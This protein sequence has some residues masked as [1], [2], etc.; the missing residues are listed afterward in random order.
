MQHAPDQSVKLDHRCLE[1]KRKVSQKAQTERYL[2][3]F[4]VASLCDL[5]STDGSGGCIHGGRCTTNCQL[6][7][8]VDLHGSSSER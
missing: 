2:E 4:S 1:L 6:S 7:A 8:C 5:L 3:E